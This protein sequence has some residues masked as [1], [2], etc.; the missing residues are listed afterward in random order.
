MGALQRKSRNEE[1]EARNRRRQGEGGAGVRKK[2]RGKKFAATT[3]IWLPDARTNEPLQQLSKTKIKGRRVDGTGSVAHR[4]TKIE[5]E[6][7]R[8]EKA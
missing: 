3:P 4:L 5:K 7:E 1:R 2:D 8:Q 6:V